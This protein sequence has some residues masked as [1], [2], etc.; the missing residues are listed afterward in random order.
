MEERFRISIYKTRNRRTRFL[1]CQSAIDL[2]MRYSDY[3]MVYCYLMDL[4]E[5]EPDLEDI[6]IRFNQD[7]R[8]EDYRASS[9]SV[10]DVVLIENRRGSMAYYVEPFG[11]TELPNFVESRKSLSIGG[12]DG[13]YLVAQLCEYDDRSAEIAICLHDKA[14]IAVQDICILR[15]EPGTTKCKVWGDE[16]CETASHEFIIPDYAEYK[17]PGVEKV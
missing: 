12:N 10:S 16:G 4:T 1:K 14:G 9:L 17:T 13:K 8:P 15:R 11:F 5:K 6:F 2:G 7:T 3:E